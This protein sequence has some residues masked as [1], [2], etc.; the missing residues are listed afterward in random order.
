MKQPR[1]IL[2]SASPRR[3]ELLETSG[4]TVEVEAAH[5][6]ESPLPGEQAKSYVS[7]LAQEKALAIARR[8]AGEAVLILG[9][10]TTVVHR[11][12][13]LGKPENP[14]EARRMLRM[15]AGTSHSVHTGVCLVH[16]DGGFERCGI[17]TTR[18]WFAPLSDADIDAY[19]ASG[20]PF[21]KAGA[22]AIQGRAGQFI[23][24]IEGSWS[25]VV[26]LPL[27]LV[28]SWMAE[29]LEGT[30]AHPHHRR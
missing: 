2:A 3:R 6:D 1:L 23:P 24:R 22:Y 12:E 13:I 25:N 4:W 27:H 20:E 10:D 11:G 9:A 8:H 30:E 14:D 29:A 5:I 26:G 16:A 19:I 18:V 17:D 15:L 21:D 28:R 7:R